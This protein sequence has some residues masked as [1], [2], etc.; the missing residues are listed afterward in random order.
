M[1]FSL[2]ETA[3]FSTFPVLLNTLLTDNVSIDLTA[4]FGFLLSGGLYSE[5]KG[6]LLA[7]RTESSG[8]DP[9]SWD[10]SYPDLQETKLEITKNSN[11]K[12]TFKEYYFQDGSS[13]WEN[14]PFTYY[15]T[16]SGT[17]L[18]VTP[19]IMDCWDTAKIKS[20]RTNY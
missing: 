14:A 12:Y 3:L 11:G 15:P 6:I 2:S 10:E 20:L 18:T 9:V 13:S 19:H 16:L 4:P 17:T 8:S 5:G 7:C 1:V